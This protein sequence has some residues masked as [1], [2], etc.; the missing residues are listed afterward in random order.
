MGGQPF[1]YE[2]QDLPWTK[3][4]EDNWQVIR[5]EVLGLMLEKPQNLRPYFINKSMSFPPK[6]WKTMGIYFWKFVI[7]ENYKKCPETVRILKTIPGLTSFSL[8]VLEAG[9]NINPHQGDTDA[10]IRCHVGI[11]I[12]G[13]LPDCGFQVG[14]EIRPWENGIT[15]PFC[16]AHTH[17]ARNNTDRKRIIL[18]LD[19]MRSEFVKKENG[20]CAHVV[21]SSVLQMLYQSYPFLGR[22]SGYFKKA[23]YHTSRIMILGFLP[24]QRLFAAM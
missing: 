5:D 20:I 16:D 9:S 13:H 18:I 22:R 6:R 23:L 24:V 12:P 7:R 3:V 15:L 19:V 11:D 14:K 2:R 21:A 10:I 1:F 8:S 4:I 17:T